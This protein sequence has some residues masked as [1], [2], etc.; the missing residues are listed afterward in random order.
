MMSLALLAGLLSGCTTIR[1]VAQER[2]GMITQNIAANAESP[3]RPIE[4]MVAATGPDM[5][6]R[7]PT[8]A[9]LH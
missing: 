8:T 6:S 3:L 7:E 4:T 5:A 1:P 9:S 2:I